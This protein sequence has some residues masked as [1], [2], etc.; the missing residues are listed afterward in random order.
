MGTRANTIKET[1]TRSGT[2]GLS[3]SKWSNWGPLFTNANGQLELVS[4]TAA[5]YYGIDFRDNLDLTGVRIFIEVVS[6]GTP[7]ADANW[8]LFPL[9]LQLD[10]NNSVYLNINGLGNLQFWT[11]VATVYTQ[12]GTDVTFSLPTHRYLA[13][14]ESGGT[15]YFEVSSDLNTW[16]VVQSTANPFSIT[17]LALGIQI[18]TD[19]IV[20]SSTTVLLDNLN[21]YPNAGQIKTPNI[22]PYPF[23]PC[24]AR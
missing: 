10:V 7:P 5:Q 15:L 2:T 6:I 9:F 14:R 21:I 4:A 12:I 16:T 20:A 8:R 24:R 17:N 13:L 22:R 11:K 23:S 18:G 1:F 3:D 19:A